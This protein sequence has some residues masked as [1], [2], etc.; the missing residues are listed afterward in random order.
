V[1]DKDREIAAGHIVSVEF[2]A[3]ADVPFPAT[4]ASL[5]I[6]LRQRKYGDL[7]ENLPEFVDLDGNQH[8]KLGGLTFKDA[9]KKVMRMQGRI[10]LRKSASDDNTLELFEPEGGDDNSKNRFF[11]HESRGQDPP[12][13]VESKSLTAG[14]GSENSKGFNLNVKAGKDSFAM[15]GFLSF[16]RRFAVITLPDEKK[17][18][19][20]LFLMSRNEPLFESA[21][22]PKATAVIGLVSAPITQSDGIWKQQGASVRGVLMNRNDSILDGDSAMMALQF[23]DKDGQVGLLS[24][25]KDLENSDAQLRMSKQNLPDGTKYKFAGNEFSPPRLC[26][27]HASVP[28]VGLATLCPGL[29]GTDLCD[30]STNC[31]MSLGVAIAMPIPDIGQQPIA[32]IKFIALDVDLDGSV[33]LLS[34]D[35]TNLTEKGFCE[36]VSGISGQ[37]DLSPCLI[38]LGT[39]N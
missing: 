36:D 28:S 20:G 9:N 7:T 12:K 21:S 16:S 38:S 27:R 24:W 23:H 5:V 33:T 32:N 25:A 14:S 30:I 26:I 19:S 4:P 29:G 39:K 35:L 8:W 22:S 1:V 34:T 37:D 10:N 17:Y 2:G 13:K 15:T 11:F 6:L 3:N 18:R 31:W